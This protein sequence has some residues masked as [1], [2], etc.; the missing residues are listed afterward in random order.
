MEHFYQDL[1]GFATKEEQGELLDTNM[2]KCLI[3]TI[4]A[5]ITPWDKMLQTSLDTWD[6]VEVEGIENVFFCGNPVKENT[7][8]IIYF[9]IEE[10]YYTMSK[11]FICALEWALKNK[12]FDYI[13][14]VNSS[15]YVDKKILAEYIKTFDDKN[16]FAGIEVDANPKWCVGWA[17]II[18]KDV[19]QNI[20][21]HKDLLR[22]DITD[23]LAIS[24]LI[25]NLQIPYTKLRMASIDAREESWA[26][27]S[28]NG[29]QSFDFIDFA[30][31]RNK[32]IPLYRV[33]FDS[34][35]N[36][37]AFLMNQLYLNL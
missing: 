29:C 22:N 16:V 30:D 32:E 10:S 18:S 25:N 12:E 4:G 27:V 13:L 15:T 33:K 9:P 24:Y 2:K 3:L 8:K 35:R 34:D 14:R 11:K 28:Y 31:L 5:Q 21:E 23:D 26:C 6:S 37:D 1:L 36:V 7:D 17:Y 20:V 19:I